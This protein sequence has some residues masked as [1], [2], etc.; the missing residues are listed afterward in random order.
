MATTKISKRGKTATVWRG[1]WGD[2]KGISVGKT[3]ESKGGMNSISSAK[4]SARYSTTGI[5]NP[6]TGKIGKRYSKF[7]TGGGF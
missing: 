2:V 3:S 6:R 7:Y 1:V 5:G 4:W